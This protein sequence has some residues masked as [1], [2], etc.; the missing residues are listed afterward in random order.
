[1]LHRDGRRYRDLLR[2]SRKDVRADLVRV[3][4]LLPPAAVFA[5]VPNLALAT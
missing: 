4:G 3:A 2:V 1:M 5:A